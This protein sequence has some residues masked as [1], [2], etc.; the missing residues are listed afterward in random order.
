MHVHVCFMFLIK[1]NVIQFIG[2]RYKDRRALSPTSLALK[3][4][5]LK[6][7][8]CTYILCTFTMRGVNE[9]H[10]P[11]SAWKHGEKVR[12]KKR[13]ERGWGEQCAA[14]T[15]NL[16]QFDCRRHHDSVFLFLACSRQ[17]KLWFPLEYADVLQYW[18]NA[19]G[20]PINSIDW[21]MR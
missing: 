3:V 14:F 20:S 6:L 12:S 13:R 17:I 10:E 4:D 21:D 8:Q 16:S 7:C 18:Q 15:R 5:H 19:V 9:K 11:L 2:I 1:I